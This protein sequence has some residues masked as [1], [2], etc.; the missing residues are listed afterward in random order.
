M[1][2]TKVSNLYCHL[3]ENY[4]LE[5]VKLLR[6]WENKVKKMANVKGYIIDVPLVQ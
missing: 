6:T 5:S 2:T 4:G 1:D 3:K